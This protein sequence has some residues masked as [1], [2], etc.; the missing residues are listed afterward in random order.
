MLNLKLTIVVVIVY[1]KCE[2]AKGCCERRAGKFEKTV[3]NR[4]HSAEN[5]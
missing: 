1:F 4:Y 2:V 5:F 3:K